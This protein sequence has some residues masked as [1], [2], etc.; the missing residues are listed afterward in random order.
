[1]CLW[2]QACNIVVYILNRYPHKALKDITS[3]EA[4][5]NEKLEV[6]DFYVFACPIYIHVPDEKRTKLEP[7]SF[8][9]IFV[10]YNKTSKAYQIYVPTQ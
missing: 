5:T 9:G 7:S 3:N 10:G 4:F 2:E 6:L 1:M 8:K